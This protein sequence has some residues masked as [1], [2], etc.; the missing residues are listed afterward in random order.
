MSPLRGLVRGFN[1]HATI[2]SSNGEPKGAQHDVTEMGLLLYF[3]FCGR[4]LDH[5]RRHI[6]VRFKSFPVNY[7]AVPSDGDKYIIKYLLLF[8]FPKQLLGIE[9]FVLDQVL[10]LDV[11]TAPPLIIFLEIVR[12]IGFQ[13]RYNFAGFIEEF[14]INAFWK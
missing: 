8:W 3:K 7:V 4:F 11:S 14:H 10:H 13:R 9:L 12:M 5:I 1:V 6:L 2:M